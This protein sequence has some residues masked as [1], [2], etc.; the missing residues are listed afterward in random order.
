MQ[1]RRSNL[2]LHRWQTE[3]MRE[4]RLKTRIIEEFIFT[5]RF[6]FLRGESIPSPSMRSMKGEMLC[7]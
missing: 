7:H 5:R 3:I 6:H 1:A 2:F 4:T